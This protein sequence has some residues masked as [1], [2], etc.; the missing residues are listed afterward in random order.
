MELFPKL[1]VPIVDINI[2]GTMNILHIPSSE[3]ITKGLNQVP[4]FWSCSSKPTIEKRSLSCV[5]SP[6]LIYG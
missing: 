2:K 3:Y 4:G 5:L 1:K 6:P